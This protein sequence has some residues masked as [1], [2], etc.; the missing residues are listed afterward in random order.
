MIETGAVRDAMSTI[1][2]VCRRSGTGES[3]GVIRQYIEK[4]ESESFDARDEIAE[5]ESALESL[6]SCLASSA[7]GTISQARYILDIW[8]LRNTFWKSSTPKL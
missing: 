5:M 6:E 4:L 8:R 2:G 3:L 7:D 1:E